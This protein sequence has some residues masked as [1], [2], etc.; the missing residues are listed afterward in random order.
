MPKPTTIEELQIE[1][2]R[3]RD[4][5]AEQGD[6]RLWNLFAATVAGIDAV[7][8]SIDDEDDEEEPEEEFSRV[9]G[10]PLRRCRFIF[11]SRSRCKVIAATEQGYCLP[12]AETPQTLAPEDAII[13]APASA[14]SEPPPFAP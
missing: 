2:V 4:L 7:M 10:S 5:A 1:A 14:T 6:D 3:L 12:H 8:L 11:P 13:D 9:S